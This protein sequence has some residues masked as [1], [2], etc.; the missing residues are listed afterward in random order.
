MKHQNPFV[1]YS[2]V[3]NNQ[4]YAALS[5]LVG[6]EQGWGADRYERAAFMVRVSDCLLGLI[7][8]QQGVARS[9]RYICAGHLLSKRV[10]KAVRAYLVLTV[11]F[12]EEGVS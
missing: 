3:Y 1:V 10:Q 2:R 5:E 8:G 4:L 6:R 9:M 12:A 7:A 11:C